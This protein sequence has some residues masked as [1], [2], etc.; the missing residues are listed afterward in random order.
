MWQG[1]TRCEKVWKGVKMSENVWKGVKMSENVWKGVTR[2]DKVWKGVARCDKV[3]H[4]MKRCHK[5]WQGVISC[6]NV[7][8]WIIRCHKA[9]QGVTSHDNVWQGRFV[10]VYNLSFYFTVAIN[11]LFY[12]FNHF[13][14]NKIT[15][16]EICL[17]FPLNSSPFWSF[18]PSVNLFIDTTN[19]SQ[20][21][22]LFS[23]S[24]QTIDDAFLFSPGPISI[25]S[26]RDHDVIFLH[27]FLFGP[28]AAQCDSHSSSCQYI[29][30]TE[31]N[32]HTTFPKLDQASCGCPLWTIGASMYL[33]LGKISLLSIIAE[34]RS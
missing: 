6:D 31:Q 17:S 30:Q 4:G 24:S 3:L 20:T 19:V 25:L 10:S 22:L 13:S 21:I 18:Y 29:W 5:V 1:M 23:C 8:R 16:P 7:L 14:I 12:Y 15:Y 33:S 32:Q 11:L 9:W 2:C 27:R 34:S 26:S 28:P